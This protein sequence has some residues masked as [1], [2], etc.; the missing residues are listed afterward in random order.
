MM[1][2]CPP[3]EKLQQ[4]LAAELRAPEF[5]GIEAHVESCP[6]CRQVL[7]RLVWEESEIDR[8]GKSVAAAPAHELTPDF[9]RRLVNRFRILRPHES[10]GLGEVYL[11]EDEEVRRTVA[12]KEIRPEYV[13]DPDVQARFLAEAEITGRLEHPGIVPV[14]GLGRYPDGR[15]FYATRFIE[16]VSLAAA[17][18]SF[19]GGRTAAPPNTGEHWGL[20]KLLGRFISACHTIA[21]AHSRGVVHRDLKPAHIMLGPY[22]ETFVVDWGLA[23]QIDKLIEKS[24][25]AGTGSDGSKPTRPTFW[26]A[27][28]TD[29]LPGDIF[30]TPQYMSP[31]QAAGRPDQVGSASDVYSLGAVLYC[32][33][34]GKAPHTDAELRTIVE[35]V[36][37][38][39]FPHPRQVNRY[40]PATLE[41]IVL[42]AMALQPSDRYR[43]P[44]ELA[45]D[46]ERW[47]ADEPV[48]VHRDPLAVR[49]ER[50]VRKNRALTGSLLAMT[51]IVATGLITWRAVDVAQLRE[52]EQQENAEHLRTLREEA[53]IQQDRTQRFRYVAEMNL[54]QQA[55]ERSQ[56]ARLKELLQPYALGTS[57]DSDLRGFEWH[58]LWRL[59]HAELLHLPRGGGVVHD[60]VFTPGGDQLISLSSTGTCQVWEATTGHLVRTLHN[61]RWMESE[62]ESLSPDGRWLAVAKDPQIK[63][64]NTSTGKELHHFPI[65]EGTGQLIFSQD[66]RMLAAVGTQG[67][68]RI[69]D[70][71]DGKTL[72]VDP[73]TARPIDT[74]FAPGTVPPALGRGQVQ[75]GKISAATFGD[76][77]KHLATGDAQGKVQIWDLTTGNEKAAFRQPKP[78]TL[79]AYGPGSE[80]LISVTSNGT[81]TMRDLRSNQELWSSSKN[82]VNDLAFSPN[83]K[84]LA[85]AC[86]ET[87][88]IVNAATGAMAF[89]L[90]EGAA[91]VRFH[92]DGRRL[93]TNG[94]DG[95]KVWDAT[96]PPEFRTLNRG[97]WPGIVS[98][99]F[100]GNTEEFAACDRSGK[101]TIWDVR[102]G[103]GEHFPSPLT[104]K[105]QTAFCCSPDGQF[106]AAAITPDET[107]PAV[108][109]VKVWNVMT[110]APVSTLKGHLFPINGIV[111]RPD[112]RQLATAANDGTVRLWDVT[113][114]TEVGFL[115]SNDPKKWR[116]LCVAFSPDGALLAAGDGEGSV[117]VW[118]AATGRQVYTL[119]IQTDVVCAVSFS[120]DGKLLAAGGTDAVMV[121]DL[122]T[123][124]RLHSLRSDGY[125]VAF[126]PDGRRLVRGGV[127]LIDLWDLTTG[128]QVL[129][130]AGH[131]QAVTCVAFSG[132]GK[133]LVTGS[134]GGAVC[135]W[136]ATPKK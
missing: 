96:G 35:K 86:P 69:W 68:L 125:S 48:T 115:K 106:A 41:A 7:E 47:L 117:T 64:W 73:R 131:R 43:S 103:E 98:G 19:H 21:Y 25:D 67:S 6:E 66:G 46:V 130:L 54:A 111:F 33:L 20:R 128:Q 28:R 59:A 16:G 11:A 8:R 135:V 1:T 79:L 63:V 87:T 105:P 27:D 18:D 84:R 91:S 42:K 94:S 136:N 56:P 134:A 120:A 72:L 76:D 71:T 100:I 36:Q 62:A 44:R 116:L 107:K 29:T 31:E 81:L 5:A 74:D 3:P 13:H 61:H 49:L 80:H 102:T 57:P 121:W 65:S 70:L 60:F 104:S 38:G 114:G 23:K 124:Q 99:T 90:R 118:E 88:L 22:G 55:Y 4:L 26:A 15:P 110:G 119:P 126:S 92:P 132:D 85:I 101:V 123:G 10:G 129:A 78:I 133:H 45:E 32:L 58:Y 40:I 83:G 34:T 109:A 89:V 50:W 127:G 97:G 112:G 24:I 39:L 77:G 17:I 30:G 12:L 52:R 51:V 95:V 2:P 37:R 122:Q 14:Y 9:R 108:M 113:R 93:A 82:T 53:I 75:V